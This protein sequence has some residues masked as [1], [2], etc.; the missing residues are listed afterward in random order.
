MKVQL[1][2]L[3]LIKQKLLLLY[4][5]CVT[6]NINMNVDNKYI[7]SASY[8]KLDN[9]FVDHLSVTSRGFLCTV[10]DVELLYEDGSWRI[11]R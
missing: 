5:F 2:E 9:L 3:E 11:T 8:V 7:V 4:D 6:N 1:T 10:N